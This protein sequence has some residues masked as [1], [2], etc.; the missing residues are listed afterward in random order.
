MSYEIIIGEILTAICVIYATKL[1]RDLLLKDKLLEAER[2]LRSR[3]ANFEANYGE[4]REKTPGLIGNALGELGIESIMGE[5]GIDPGILNNP[6]VRGLIKS[7]APK[8]LDQ[9]QK[10]TEGSTQNQSFL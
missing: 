1:F 2:K 3:I 7:Y 4:I 6:M 10:K 9:I 5:L 8:I